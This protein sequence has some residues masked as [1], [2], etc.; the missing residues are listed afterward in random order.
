MVKAGGALADSPAAA[1]GPE[2]STNRSPASGNSKAV[3]TSTS[4]STTP[5]S[6]DKSNSEQRIVPGKL[7]GE[8][9]EKAIATSN[10]ALLAATS[11]QKTTDVA[12]SKQITNKAALGS[13]AEVSEPNGTSQRKT[14]S[15]TSQQANQLTEQSIT[16]MVSAT[17]RSTGDIATSDRLLSGQ[18]LQAE[19]SSPEDASENQATETTSSTVSNASNPKVSLTKPLSNQ[20]SEATS[21][22]ETSAVDAKDELGPSAQATSL[23]LTTRPPSTQTSTTSFSAIQTS[24]AAANTTEDNATPPETNEGASTTAGAAG[25]NSNSN[26]APSNTETATN[27]SSPT[28]STEE[29]NDLSDIVGLDDSEIAALQKDEMDPIDDLTQATTVPSVLFKRSGNL[30]RG[31]ADL[32]QFSVEE[33]GV[34]TADL[35]DLSADADVQLIQDKNK[36]GQ[37][38]AGEIVAWEWEHNKTDESIRHFLQKGDYVLRVLEQDINSSETQYSVATSFTASEVDDRAFSIEVIYKLGSE[39]LNDEARAAIASAAD[40]WENVIS[41]SSFDRPLELAL[42]IY[43]TTNETNPFLAYAGPQT[44]RNTGDNLVPVVGVAVLNNLYLDDYNENPDYLESVLRHE[45]G[46]VLGLGVIWDKRGNDLVD[47]DKGVYR[48]DSY[49]GQ[50]YGELLGTGIATDVP[51][52]L[53]SLTH[54]SE[55]IFDEEIMTPRAEGIGTPLPLSQLTISSLRDLGWH[56]NYGAAEAFSLDASQ[57][58]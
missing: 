45:I 2:T 27:T 28:S 41:H 21:K 29:T 12:T 23:P 5:T 48:G 53:E 11:Q 52:D 10:P 40:Y 57:V 42:G 1:K 22:A 4:P 24:T 47:Q 20:V 7:N 9:G 51:L 19:T 50:A 18:S 43:G 32:Y 56:V 35:T 33:A 55:E 30:E 15:E 17:K 14:A 26:Q 44:Y 39:Q 58:A 36:N 54:W 3:D 16:T 6:K 46:H 13:E 31:S 34:F 8:R 49:A 25:T 38:D 37:V